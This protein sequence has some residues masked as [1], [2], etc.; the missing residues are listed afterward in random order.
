[1]LAAIK[2]LDEMFAGQ[3]SPNL[4]TLN[5]LLRGCMRNADAANAEILFSRMESS[6]KLSGDAS[7]LEYLVKA[8]C[9][10]G[11]EEKAW[12]VAKIATVKMP[13]SPP[14]WA[15]VALLSALHGKKS[16]KLDRCVIQL[17]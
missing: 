5:T 11:L 8:V 12:E 9:A 3:N 13:M 1:M 17:L 15:A 7:S 6:L 16:G 10:E 2:L 4:R 14:A